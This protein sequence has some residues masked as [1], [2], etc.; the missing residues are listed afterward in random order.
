[1]SSRALR[2]QWVVVLAATSVSALAFGA[3]DPFVGHWKLNSSRSTYIDRMK[4][5]AKGPN[6]YAFTFTG[7]P[8]AETVVAD[9]KD[10]PGQ[11]G[12]TV[13]V[14]IAP[15]GT[16]RFI[17]KK[18]GRTIIDALWTLAANGQTLGDTFTAAQPNG[19]MQKLHIAF[20]RAA[21]GSGFAGTWEGTTADLPAL[22]CR[23]EPY[24]GDGLT[25]AYPSQQMTQRMKF[26]GKDYPNEGPAMPAGSTSSGHRVN[27]RTIRAISKVKGTVT[28]SREATVSADGKTLTMTI[29]PAGQ[30]KPNVFVFERQ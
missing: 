24:E 5:E 23:I 11:G 30:S 21:P 7:S 8:E 28:S 10:H 12:T 9:G 4:V 25:F 13:S 1:M 16:L 14:T 18:E 26:D 22:E 15:P 2:L 27:E 3:D 17:R 29:R 6:T 20:E 19:S